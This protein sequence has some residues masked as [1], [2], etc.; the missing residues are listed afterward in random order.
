MLLGR[1]AGRARVRPQAD[2]GVRHGQ[3]ARPDHLD[4][5]RRRRRSD[6]RR[7]GDAVRARHVQG[8]AV[9]GR[10][11][12]RP[13]HRHPRHPA[14][15]AWLGRRL[16]ALLVIAAAATA[17]M[18]GAA[19]VPRLRRQGGRLRNAAAQRVARRVAPW[20]L[21][22]VVTGSVFTTIYSLRFLYGAF[23]RKGGAVRARVPKCTRRRS[24]PVRAG[25]YSPPRAWCSVCAG[26]A[27][28]GARPYAD[29]VPAG[30]IT[31]WR[32]GTGE[33]SA[34]AV[35]GGAGCGHRGVHR[36]GPAAPARGPARLPLGNADRIYDAVCATWSF[37]RQGD[38]RHP[39]RFDCRRRSRSSCRPWSGAGRGA[40]ARRPRPSGVRL[41]DGPLQAV[42]GLDHRWRPHSRDRAA[43]PAGRGAAG[44]RHRLR[45]RRD[46]R[47]ARRARPGADAVPGG[48]A[49]VGD[50]RAGAAHA[51]PPRPIGRRMRRL[52]RATGTAGRGGRRQRDRAGAHSRWPRAPPRRSPTCCP[53]PPTTAA[54][55]NTVNVLLVDIRAWDTIGEISVLL[56]AATGVAS[57][58][59][60]TGDLVP[61]RG[62]RGRPARYR[63]DASHPDSPAVGDITWLRG[64]EYAIRGTG[65][66]CSRS[67]RGSSSR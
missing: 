14:S 10:R 60:G 62:C 51:C 57:W 18:A 66:W 31:T 4:G 44:R 9:H 56:V 5:R 7:A 20:V 27:G 37:R 8:R 12:H 36:P 11:H 16:P 26:A 63:P 6:A 45:L 42:V 49:D 19:T 33:P 38:R 40:D 48:D 30:G 17:S 53:T 43:Q 24:L 47:L 58:C 29:T 32:C 23:A 15:S 41:W 21:A 55:L 13:R 22:G 67:R 61:H 35:G 59:S 2:P 46:L 28:D 34:A 39:A 25:A 3:P 52:R 54:W 50:L 65:R 1:L 64:S